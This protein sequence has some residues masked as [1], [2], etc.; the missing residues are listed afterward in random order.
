MS[1]C[2]FLCIYLLSSVAVCF[3][4]YL[5]AFLCLCLLSSVSICLS[6]ISVCFPLYPGAGPGGLGKT[7]PPK[8]EVGGRPMHWSPIFRE[9]VLSDVCERMNRVKKLSY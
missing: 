6:S 7:V 1:L 4:L 2:A 3:P 8:F 5:F 9:V